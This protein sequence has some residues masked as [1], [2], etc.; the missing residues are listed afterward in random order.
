[1]ERATFDLPTTTSSEPPPGLE[2]KG[3]SKTGLCFGGCGRKVPVHDA[4]GRRWRSLCAECQAKADARRDEADVAA[5]AGV[6]LGSAR[7]PGRMAEWSFASFPDDAAGVEARVRVEGWLAGYLA[8]ERR[9]LVLGGP[10][11][12]G[13]TGLAVS[14]ARELAAALVPVR[15]V[16]WRDYLHDVVDRL[17]TDEP[18]TDSALY[19]VAVLVLD[20]LG[21]ER[22]TDFALNELAVLVERRWQRQLPMV[23]TTN[24]SGKDLVDRLGHADLVVGARIVSRLFEAAQ[25]ERVGG[26]DRRIA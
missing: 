2:F 4:F 10:V 26:R 13:K 11:G 6:M 22:P 24:Y 21:A 14:C 15:F 3:R 17:H 12:V 1:V 9:N 20:D 25:L 7:I 5:L 18:A 16:V 23:V 8:G 19:G